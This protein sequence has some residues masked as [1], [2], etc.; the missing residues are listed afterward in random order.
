[1]TIFRLTA[2]LFIYGLVLSML[3][4]GAAL[5][6]G[7]AVPT[8]MIA[9][10]SKRQR[11]GE[12]SL[13]DLGTGLRQSVMGD[14][15]NDSSPAWSPDGERLAFVS[16]RD[17]NYEIYTVRF[18][19]SDLRRLTDIAATD[20]RP[21]WSPDGTEIAFISDRTISAPRA[22]LMDSDGRNL[23]VFPGL[24][25]MNYTPLWSNDGERLAFLNDI[26]REVHILDT[27]DMSLVRIEHF[28]SV[29]SLDWSPDGNQIGF[30]TDRGGSRRFELYALDLTTG[31]IE[32]LSTT[33]NYVSELD[34]SPDGQHILY[35]AQNS[36]GQFDI[37]MTDADGGRPQ[38]IAPGE[39]PVWRPR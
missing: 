33:H 21:V 16:S 2:Q 24:P 3:L 36:L 38:Y 9:Y 37:Y 27:E 34:W 22:Y 28:G 12:L 1:M 14:V 6:I 30:V 5:V 29:L 39:S 15:A 17:G 7:Q 20:S 8:D 19:G 18:D 23:R 4:T 35:T 11:S 10:I 13:M 31:F 32:Q 25:A 26:A